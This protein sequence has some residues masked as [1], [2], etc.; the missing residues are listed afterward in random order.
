MTPRGSLFIISAP[1]GAGKSSLIK[2]LLER[3][4][5]DGRLRLSVSHT[6]R[7]PRPGEED[8]VH[9]HFVDERE[10]QELVDRGA[11]YEHAEVFGHH[12][13]TS[14]EIVERWQGEG[15]DVLFDIDWQGARLI[16]AQSP[17]AHSVFIM[18]PSLHALRERLE[19][20]GQDSAEVIASR[21]ARAQ[22][23]ISHFGEYEYVLINDDFDQCLMQL[24]SVIEGCRRQLSACREEAEALA[25]S[26]M[27]E[28]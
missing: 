15:H 5:L 8:H 12:Y 10:F 26:I 14:R 4:N 22:A 18:P 11:F 23:E 20:R 16:R 17:G 27:G 9:Y 1:S 3:F 6:T 7:A 28:S 2:A 25:R 13:G 21:M 19:G 24:R